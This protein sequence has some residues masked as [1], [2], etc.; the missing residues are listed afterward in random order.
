MLL[1]PN[2]SFYS[3]AG[4]FYNNDIFGLFVQIEW[5]SWVGPFNSIATRRGNPGQSIDGG[6]HPTDSPHDVDHM[7]YAASQAV[8]SFC[9]DRQKQVIRHEI[10]CTA[11][12]HSILC[13]TLFESVSCC[14]DGKDDF[15]IWWVHRLYFASFWYLHNQYLLN[16]LFQPKAFVLLLPLAYRG[17]DCFWLEMVL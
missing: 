5:S 12:K 3:W 13:K 1:S 14:Q 9:H 15:N 4:L 17:L 16:C 8:E 11:P 6:S 2:S 7:W 10:S